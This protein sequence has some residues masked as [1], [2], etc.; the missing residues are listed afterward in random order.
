MDLAFLPTKGIVKN[1]VMK[2]ANKKIERVGP[3]MWINEKYRTFCP[4]FH[5]YYYN[6]EWSEYALFF[7]HL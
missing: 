2:I 4:N 6:S 3:P 1:I 7:K 5:G